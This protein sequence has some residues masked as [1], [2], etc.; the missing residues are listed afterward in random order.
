MV[1]EFFNYYSQVLQGIGAIA[2]ICIALVLFFIG[3][4]DKNKE[5]KI[6]IKIKWFM[7]VILVDFNKNLINIISMIETNIDKEFNDCYGQQHNGLEEFRRN[8]INLFIEL[9]YKVLLLFNNIYYY[10]AN[11]SDKLCECCYRFNDTV[12]KDI[13]E[14]NFS[15]IGGNEMFFKQQLKL[16]LME[17]KNKISEIIFKEI[18]DVDKKQ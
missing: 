14:M 4:K 12:I 8:L 17:F 16:Q 15:D 5:L 2:N 1:V 3:R 7:D 6:N 9:Q 10:N 11:A 18:I 13:S